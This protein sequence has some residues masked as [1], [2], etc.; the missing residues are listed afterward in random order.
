MDKEIEEELNNTRSL[1][2]RQLQQI[3]TSKK[4][5]KPGTDSEDDLV[6][7]SSKTFLFVFQIMQDFY[8]R[9]ESIYIS[10]L[11]WAEQID[12]LKDVIFELKEVKNDPLLQERIN[13]LFSQSKEM[14]EEQR[15]SFTKIYD[16]DK[17][18]K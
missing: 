15:K 9:L 12:L 5:W 4:T 18:S 3:E 17:S 10:N 7:I 8:M 11:A 14:F 13:K 16:N 2:H 1:I 6:R